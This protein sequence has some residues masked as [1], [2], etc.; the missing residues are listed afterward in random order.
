MWNTSIIQSPLKLCNKFNWSPYIVLACR[1]K[2]VAILLLVIHEVNLQLFSFTFYKN[3]KNEINISPTPTCTRKGVHY[4]RIRDCYTHTCT[5]NPIPLP[6]ILEKYM[7]G[8]KKPPQNHNIH[9]KKKDLDIYS[10]HTHK[11]ENEYLIR[12]FE[13]PTWFFCLQFPNRCLVH[14][15]FWNELE[16]LKGIGI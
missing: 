9:Q 7:V 5:T 4:F 11:R 15:R 16:S 3:I 14:T 6:K 2:F 10:C 12:S 8:S 1:H 13:V